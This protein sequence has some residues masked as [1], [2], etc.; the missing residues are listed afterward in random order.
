MTLKRCALLIGGLGMLAGCSNYYQVR[1]PQ[2]GNV[3]YT[4]ALTDRAG[5]AVSFEDE[6]TD[7]DVT[8]QESEVARIDRDLYHARTA[9]TSM[10][11]WIMTWTSSRRRLTSPVRNLTA[12]SR[13]ATLI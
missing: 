3:Y 5:G 10:W 7:R 4:R 13:F 2:S 1:D 6:L 8:L 12:R 9:T 11:T